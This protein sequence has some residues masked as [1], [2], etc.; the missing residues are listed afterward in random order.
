MEVTAAPHVARAPV[1]D[2]MQALKNSLA[3]KPGPAAERKSLVRAVPKAG[4]ETMPAR[5]SKRKTG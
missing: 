5:K 3:A 1:I 4:L 2:L